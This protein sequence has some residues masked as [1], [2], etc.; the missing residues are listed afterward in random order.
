MKEIIA[1]IAFII[2]LAAFLDPFGRYMP[3]EAA[4]MQMLALLVIFAVFAVFVWKEKA[5]D[6]REALHALLAGR[7]A[8]LVGAGVLVIGVIVQSLD[9]AVDPVRAGVSNGVD[10]WLVHALGAMIL[11]K[12]LGR[13]YAQRRQ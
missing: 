10:S 9:H 1:S 7:I 6:E 4:M 11:A 13:I 5:R 8:F 3:S 12:M 2:L